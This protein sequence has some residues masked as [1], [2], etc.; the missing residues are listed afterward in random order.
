MKRIMFFVVWGISSCTTDSSKQEEKNIAHVKRMFDAF[1]SHDWK[2][3]SEH[4]ADSSLFLDPAFGT[5]Y[6]YQLR[7]ETASKYAKME[8]M[9]PTIHDEVVGIFANGDK[10]AVEFVSTGTS[11]DSVSFILPI[12]CI[13]T[14]QNNLI[15]KDATYYNNCQ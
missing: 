7:S 4:Y 14:L 10:V 2:S 3:M 12:I 6:V 1:N 9:F 15:V 5:D 11:D 13:L 8:Q